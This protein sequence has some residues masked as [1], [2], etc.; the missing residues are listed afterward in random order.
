M[1]ELM[2]SKTRAML[3]EALRRAE[4]V[5]MAS[6]NRPVHDPV[7]REMIYPAVIAVEARAA[8]AQAKEEAQP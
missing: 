1:S 6:F 4:I 3:V 8:L 5:A 7:R 2:D